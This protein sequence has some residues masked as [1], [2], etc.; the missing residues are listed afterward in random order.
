M[1]AKGNSLSIFLS[2]EPLSSEG[3]MYATKN[4][5]RGNMIGIQTTFAIL[6][7]ML[8]E[9]IEIYGG[10]PERLKNKKKVISRIPIKKEMIVYENIREI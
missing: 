8:S 9:E 10:T 7:M 5:K 3:Y 4:V 1:T 2:A 6:E